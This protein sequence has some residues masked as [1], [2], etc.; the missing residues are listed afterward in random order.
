MECLRQIDNK[1]DDEQRG[2]VRRLYLLEEG[3]KA[4]NTDTKTRAETRQH[5]KFEVPRANKNNGNATLCLKNSV[6]LNSSQ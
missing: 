2:L 6:F 5:K 1:N 3:F 4:F